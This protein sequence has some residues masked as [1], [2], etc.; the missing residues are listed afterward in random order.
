MSD[1]KHPAR[2]L[3]NNE[4]LQKLEMEPDEDAMKTS[5]LDRTDLGSSKSSNISAKIIE[6]CHTNYIQKQKENEFEIFVSWVTWGE[7]KIN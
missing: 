4:E 5:A 1:V 3:K 2:K 7:Q 6:I